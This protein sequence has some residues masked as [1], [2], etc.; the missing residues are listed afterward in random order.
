M[1][2]KVSE[3]IQTTTEHQRL[4]LCFDGTGNQFRGD[5]SDTNVVKIFS[6]LARDSDHQYHYYQPGIGTYVLGP[7]SKTS[8]SIKNG[9]EKLFDS[10]W[11]ISFSDHVIA[12]Y[13]FM[14][15]Y[16]TPNDDIYLFGF[17]RGAYTARFLAE[18]IDHIGL[19]SK[20]NEEMVGFAWRTYEQY[21]RATPGTKEWKEKKR[22]MERFKNTFCKTCDIKFLGLFDCVNSTALFRDQYRPMTRP[23]AKHIR[24]AVAIDEKRSKFRASLFDVSPTKIEVWKQQNELDGQDC[25]I[26]ERWFAG[27]H[28]NIG[29][30]NRTDLS[31]AAQQDPILSDIALAW[32]M[33]ELLQL[34]ERPLER[35]NGC[36]PL[37]WDN[38]SIVE[39][40]NLAPEKEWV[41]TQSSLDR[42]MQ[43]YVTEKE[44]RDY[45]L[46]DPCSVEHIAPVVK[47]CILAREKKPYFYLDENEVAWKDT[48]KPK[49]AETSKIRRKRQMVVDCMLS[50]SRYLFTN[51]TGDWSW[52]K[53]FF[54]VWKARHLTFV[55]NFM[56]YLPLARS[57]LDEVALLNEIKAAKEVRQRLAELTFKRECDMQDHLTTSRTA[58]QRTDSDNRTTKEILDNLNSEVNPYTKWSTKRFPPN[59]GS[60]RDL[61]EDANLHH[62]VIERMVDEYHA[63]WNYRPDNDH[64]QDALRKYLH[65]NPTRFMEDREWLNEYHSSHGNKH[66]TL[67][68]WIKA[69]V[70]APFAAVGLV[71]HSNSGYQPLRTNDR[72]L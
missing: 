42:G 65:A 39:L 19:L 20:G 2:T 69:L 15:R 12:G 16:Y 1:A 54:S 35:A 46:S 14:M 67:F 56:E 10:M 62:S 44:L 68:S 60:S 30:G 11:G 24:H 31:E 32:M 59:L 71:G 22:H 6:M 48:T 41:Q 3:S 64:F 5:R 26:K 47:K 72:V 66:S 70:K 63:D 50:Y 36:M 51:S 61:W 29:G 37:R 21:M 13:V 49:G 52:S 27:N 40:L 58:L 23:P 53:R 55:W 43:W 28:C 17:S 7:V 4:V 18:M 57:E 25:S 33:K 9:T 38:S 45:K 34:H 8:D